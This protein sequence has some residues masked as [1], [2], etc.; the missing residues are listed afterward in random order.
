MDQI[1]YVKVTL[2]FSPI[3]EQMPFLVCVA[4]VL[5]APDAFEVWS[6]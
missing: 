6:T 4:V 2:Y 1:K 5:S 3:S